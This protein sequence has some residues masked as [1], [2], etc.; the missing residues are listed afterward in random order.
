VDKSE[1][2]AK[3][4]TVEDFIH[5][6]KHKNSLENF[7]AKNENFVENGTIGRLLM[8]SPDEVEAI[9]QESIKEFKK[10]MNEDESG[11]L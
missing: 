8:M 7:L 11:D 10:E 9:Y 6:P 1:M 3:I 4:R 2:Q 5:S